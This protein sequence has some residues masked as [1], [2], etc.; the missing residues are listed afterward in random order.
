MNY[1]LRVMNYELR[2]MKKNVDLLICL[3]V[4]LPSTSL[5]Q[6]SGY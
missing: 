2:I 5:R 1:E 4:I 3:F 6:Q